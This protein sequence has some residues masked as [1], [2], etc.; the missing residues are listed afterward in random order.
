M[1]IVLGLR[2][3]ENSGV[4]CWI[5][6]REEDALRGKFNDSQDWEWNM[7]PPP[8]DRRLEDR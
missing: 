2:F 5:A 3:E 7:L 4:F 6:T 8:L 1:L